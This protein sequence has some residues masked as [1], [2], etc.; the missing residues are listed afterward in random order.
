[1][2]HHLAKKN[3]ERIKRGKF[4]AKQLMNESFAYASPNLSRSFGLPHTCKINI[5]KSHCFSTSLLTSPMRIIGIYKVDTELVD[6][7]RYN[8]DSISVSNFVQQTNSWNRLPHGNCFYHFL[9]RYH[10]FRNVFLTVDI[11][12]SARAHEQVTFSTVSCT[13]TL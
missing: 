1:M 2:S 3:P 10:H 5:Y 13:A 6:S 11:F 7:I 12:E 4:S 8:N 9:S